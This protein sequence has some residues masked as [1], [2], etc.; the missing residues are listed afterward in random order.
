[1]K[2]SELLLALEI[3]LLASAVAVLLVLVLVQLFPGLARLLQGSR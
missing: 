3:V 2:R 1:M